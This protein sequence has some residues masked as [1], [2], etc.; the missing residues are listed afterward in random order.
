MISLA[1]LLWA[2]GWLASLAIN[3]FLEWPVKV[4]LFVA[5]LMALVSPYFVGLTTI[6]WLSDRCGNFN[7]V[8]WEKRP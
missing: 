4:T 8:L 3:T 7:P 2:C 1:I 6:I 5:I